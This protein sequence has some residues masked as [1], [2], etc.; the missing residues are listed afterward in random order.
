MSLEE[1]YLAAL[2]TT[3]EIVLLYVLFFFISPH[4]R[5]QR[6]RARAHSVVAGARLMFVSDVIRGR[7][8]DQL[9]DLLGRMP[10]PGL[11]GRTRFAR[12]FRIE[13]SGICA[14]VCAV[15]C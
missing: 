1:A 4:S 12:P 3:E 9:V 5:G 8:A 7:F 15:H 11:S 13:R 2:Q 6:Q 14:P 10:P